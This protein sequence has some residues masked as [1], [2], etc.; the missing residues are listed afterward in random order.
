MRRR[1]SQVGQPGQQALT[2]GLD[3]SGVRGVIDRD[4]PDVDAVTIT[5]RGE[6]LQRGGVAADDGVGRGR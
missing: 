4:G 2:R 1:R 5:G 3:L 6:L